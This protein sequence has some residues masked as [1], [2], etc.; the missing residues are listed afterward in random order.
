[1]LIEWTS[2]AWPLT[3]GAGLHRDA[4]AQKLATPAASTSPTAVSLPGLPA[5]RRASPSDPGIDDPGPFLRLN[6]RKGPA[7]RSG[8]RI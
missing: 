4:R 8:D 7:N 5:H 1:M 2:E 3:A 6:R